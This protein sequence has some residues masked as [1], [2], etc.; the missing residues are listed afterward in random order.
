MKLLSRNLNL[1]DYALSLLARNGMKNFAVLVVYSAVIFLLSSFQLIT[2]ALRENSERILTSAPDITVQLMS[3]GRQ[4]TFE[5]DPVPALD[6]IYGISQVRKRVWGYYFDE[7]NGANYTVMGLDPKDL[8]SKQDISLDWGKLPSK[9]G[10]VVLA[11]GVIENMQLS[12]RKRFSLF[13]PDLSMK[14]FTLVGQFTDGTSLVTG[15]MMLMTLL[16]A[17]DLFGMKKRDFTDLLVEVGNPAE[18]DT[19]AVKISNRIAGSRVVTRK[20]IQK[21]YDVVF[22]WRSGVGSVCLLTSLFA[23]IILAWDRASGLSPDERREMA[24][25]KVVGW[26][27]NDIIVLRFWESAVVA[28]LSFLV[29]YSFSWLHVTI[30]EAAL[31]KPVLLGWSVLRP[32]YDLLPPFLFSDFLLIFTC[33][34]VPYL[35]ATIVPA[36]KSSVVRPDV[37]I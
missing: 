2:S 14:S 7:K 9:T 27:S 26:Q 15:D 20:Q 13:R 29:G 25:L 22:S 8:S 11:A 30:G 3:A 1:L 33:S 12:G 28:L 31:F 17:N 18:I 4:K 34:I 10:E 37:V 23:F 16:D 5:D 32:D 24:I 19:I 6:G 35:I 36:W 21:T